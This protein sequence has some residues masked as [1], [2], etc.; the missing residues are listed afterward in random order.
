MFYLSQLLAGFDSDAAKQF[1]AR[2]RILGRPIS[3]I[4]AQIATI[5]RSHN[6]TLATRNVADFEECGITIVNPWEEEL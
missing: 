5:T 1:A 3:Q 6:A 4:D 2:R